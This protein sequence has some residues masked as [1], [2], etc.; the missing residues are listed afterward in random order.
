MSE[1]LANEEAEQMAR[2]EEEKKKAEDE[3]EEMKRQC[4]ESAEDSMA[5]SS[6]S[7]KHKQKGVRAALKRLRA[8]FRARCLRSRASRKKVRSPPSVFLRSMLRG[9]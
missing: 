8:A 6:A 9:S 5:I 1:K 3:I 4:R 2:A 7:Q